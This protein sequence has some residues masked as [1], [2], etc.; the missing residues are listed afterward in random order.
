MAD[1]SGIN[2][3]NCLGD[4]E[5]FLANKTIKVG[6]KIF[7]KRRKLKLFKGKKKEALSTSQQKIKTSKGQPEVGLVPVQFAEAV[8]RKPAI[9]AL[10]NPNI[11]S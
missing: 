10:E 3:Y 1:N 8:N 11:I 4:L 2:T 9:R 5:S 6:K 7:D